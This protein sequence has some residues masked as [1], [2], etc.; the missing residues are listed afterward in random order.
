[1][2]KRPRV[3]KDLGKNICENPRKLK[4]LP[5]DWVTGA[6][7]AAAVLDSS[8]PEKS[9]WYGMCRRPLFLSLPWQHAFHTLSLPLPPSDIL[10]QRV[11]RF[12]FQVTRRG[13]KERMKI[14]QD[15]NTSLSKQFYMPKIYHNSKFYCKFLN[16]DEQVHVQDRE[17]CG[18]KNG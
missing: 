4:R 9:C 2:E 7:A 6:A 13:K 3:K 15:T 17:A 14:E 11:D 5:F 1:M 10:L 12:G 18:K 16:V 8:F